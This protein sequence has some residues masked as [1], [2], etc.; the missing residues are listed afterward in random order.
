M[1]GELD[2]V[3]NGGFTKIII[4][5]KSDQHVEVDTSEITVRDGEALTRHTGEELI[6]AGR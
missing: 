2:S 3:A 4:H 5:F 6:T 1:N